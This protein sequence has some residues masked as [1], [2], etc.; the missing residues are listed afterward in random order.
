MK[1]ITYN[2]A[3]VPQGAPANE[4]YEGRIIRNLLQNSSNYLLR[5]A[6]TLAAG[7]QWH[8]AYAVVNDYGR[9][10]V[11]AISI[12]GSVGSSGGWLAGGGH[13]ALSPS[14]GLG[15][16]L[17][18]HLV[19]QI[20]R[21]IEG[22]DNALEI[23]IVLSTGEFL[24]VNNYQYSDLF[25]ALRGGGGSTYGIVTSVTYCTY[26]SVPIQVYEYQADVANSSVMPELVEG[27]L[28]YQTQFTDDGWGGYGNISDQQL[29]FVY[30]APNMTD[31]TAIATT[32]A[33][34][35]YTASLA[36]FGVVSAEQ[37]YYFPSWYELYQL[38]SS[39]GVQNGVNLMMTSRLLSRDT[40]A[41]N[42]A[43]VAEV[44]L[45]CSAS[46][47]YVLHSSSVRSSLE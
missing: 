3:F 36:P 29:S 27:L 10:M 34:H 35:N 33:W 40:V 42:Y 6:V 18:D 4:T 32:Q 13:S 44:L 21:P 30:F 11:G 9:L 38:L 45:N 14:Y 31:D 41:N 26:P 24:T 5:V 1:N 17:E 43:E 25:W 37:T 20:N 19:H 8:E 23:S 16:I 2:S 15:K 46:L 39:S 22:V 47:K 12:G 28:R 7:V